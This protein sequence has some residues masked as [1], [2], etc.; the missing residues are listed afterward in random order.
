MGDDVTKDARAEMDEAFFD[1]L[2]ELVEEK[3]RRDS[4]DM[5]RNSQP[6]DGD[7]TS[8]GGDGAEDSESGEEDVEGEDG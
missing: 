7:D 4:L 2:R 1:R 5:V 8:E 3:N 6:R